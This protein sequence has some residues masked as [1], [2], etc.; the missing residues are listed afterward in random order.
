MSNVDWTEWLEQVPSIPVEGFAD[1][2]HQCAG[3]CDCT[4]RSDLTSYCIDL[5]NGDNPREWLHAAY[6]LITLCCL[7]EEEAVELLVGLYENAATDY[8]RDWGLPGTG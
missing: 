3:H 2:M 4:I 5:I 8:G 6:E 1:V 7:Q